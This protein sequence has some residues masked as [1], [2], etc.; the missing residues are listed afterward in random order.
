M[1]TEIN[2]REEKFKA[3]VFA[4]ANYNATMLTQFFDYWSETNK[5]G[6]KMRWEMEKTWDLKKRLNRWYTNDKNWNHAKQLNSASNG[7]HNYGKATGAISLI[8]NLKNTFD[9]GRVQGS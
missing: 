5:S 2:E 7:A 6:K 4:F 1:N 3:D 8:N 9:T